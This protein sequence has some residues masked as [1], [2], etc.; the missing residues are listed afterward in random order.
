M[1]WKFLLVIFWIALAKAQTRSTNADKSLKF[2]RIPKRKLVRVGG[3]QEVKSVEGRRKD[4]TE[5]EKVWGM[6]KI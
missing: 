2:Y 1:Q 5:G 6:A 4:R 3:R